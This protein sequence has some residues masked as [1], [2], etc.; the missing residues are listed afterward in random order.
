MPEVSRIGDLKSRKGDGHEKKE[1]LPPGNDV[2]W[3]S[4]ALNGMVVPS[5][6]FPGPAR[7]TT[8]RVSKSESHSGGR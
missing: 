2:I 3:S 4:L 6:T 8:Q 5:K 7:T 1:R